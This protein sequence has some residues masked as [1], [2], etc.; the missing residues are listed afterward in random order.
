[1]RYVGGNV[2][3]LENAPNDF[4]NSVFSIV[5]VVK[6]GFLSSSQVKSS[7]LIMNKISSQ[8]KSES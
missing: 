2:A 5:G 3:K 4:H 6:S 7:L 8:V 1:M